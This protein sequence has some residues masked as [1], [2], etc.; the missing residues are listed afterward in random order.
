MKKTVILLLSALLL[1]TLL[2]SLS[3]A[4]GSLSGTAKTDVYTATADLSVSGNE[5]V[6]TVTFTNIPY[7]ICPSA[8]GVPGQA[9]WYMWTVVEN[10]GFGKNENERSDELLAEYGDMGI[11]AE[12]ENVR[13]FQ[14]MLAD[15]G[16]YG[17][18]IDGKYDV[19]TAAAMMMFQSIRFI[20]EHENQSLSVE[21]VEAVADEET[22]AAISAET[23]GMLDGVKGPIS[24]FTDEGEDINKLQQ[25]LRKLGFY[26]GDLTGHVGARTE[27]AIMQYRTARG[28][29]STDFNLAFVPDYTLYAN[30]QKLENLDGSIT[31]SSKG[32]CT[33]HVRFA[34]PESTSNM[35]LRPA[36]TEVT[37]FDIAL[38]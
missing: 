19:E 22:L 26:E 3:C 17:G 5:L 16:Y 30:G 15:I 29:N 32:T 37:S 18:E 34:L 4:Q 36:N 20:M 10:G 23:G 11:G 24:M 21:L 13:R 2:P 12:G 9:F 28:M 35:T 6:G 8:M 14:Q 33:L 38:K 25:A 1:A 31:D 27:K 7:K